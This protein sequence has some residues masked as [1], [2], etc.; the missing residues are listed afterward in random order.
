M[1]LIS[2]SSKQTWVFLFIYEK[3]AD[4]VLLGIVTSVFSKGFWPSV[5]KP[6]DVKLE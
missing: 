2:L 4:V 6:L 1:A 3:K 5:I